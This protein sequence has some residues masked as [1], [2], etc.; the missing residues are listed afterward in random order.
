MLWFICGLYIGLI[1]GAYIMHHKNPDGGQPMEE[2]P[3]EEHLPL[4][5]RPEPLLKPDSVQYFADYKKCGEWSFVIY[6]Q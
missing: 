2:K 5:T 1:V 6:R 3:K 4:K